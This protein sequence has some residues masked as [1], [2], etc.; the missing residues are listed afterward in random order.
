MSCHIPTGE[1]PGLR[2]YFQRILDLYR[3]INRFDDAIR[4]SNEKLISHRESLEEI[5]PNIAQIYIFIGDLTYNI[6]LKFYNY[7]Q[8][9]NIQQKC[10]PKDEQAII[11]C[12]NK[13]D[14]SMFVEYFYQNLTL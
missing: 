11:I 8:A 12:Q 9:L 3:Q 7:S 2:K 4:F 5:H 6:E 13:I 10:Y 14:N 1:H